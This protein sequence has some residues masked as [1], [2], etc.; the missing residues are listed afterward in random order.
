MA[1]RNT[2]KGDLTSRRSILAPRPQLARH[3]RLHHP[4]RGQLSRPRADRVDL[5]V[6]PV[7]PRRQR[8][9]GPAG[10]Q[11]LVVRVSVKSHD[12]RHRRDPN[13]QPPGPSE[14]R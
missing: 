14:Y 8:G 2:G 5:D 13:P 4:H 6:V 11:D 1:M 7:A 12:R 10:Q 3:R 9:D